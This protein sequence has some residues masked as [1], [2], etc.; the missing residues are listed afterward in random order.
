M[1]RIAILPPMKIF[2]GYGYMTA[3]SWA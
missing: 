3:W 2:I 1:S